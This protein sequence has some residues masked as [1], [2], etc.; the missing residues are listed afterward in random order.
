[1]RKKSF[2]LIVICFLLVFWALGNLLILTS[3]LEKINENFPPS[4]PTA[5]ELK[6]VEEGIEI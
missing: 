1:M 6:Q 2:W 3:R 5:E 4:P